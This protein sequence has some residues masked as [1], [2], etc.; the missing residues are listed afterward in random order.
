MSRIEA[1]DLC[2]RLG[3]RQ[4]LAGF[5]AG[6]QTGQVTL[7][8]GRNGA[9]KS[10]LMD[11]LAGLRAPDSGEV[12]LDDAG[13]L[14][15][16]PRVRARSLTFLPQSQDIAWALD[17]RTLVGLGR[18]P[19]RG[20][21]GPSDEDHAA[22]R[23]A[24]RQAGVEALADRDVL[25]LSGGERSRMLIAR[26]LAGAPDWLLADEPL[27]GLDPGHQLDIAGLFRALA[28][29]QGMGVVLTLHDLTLAARIADQVVLMADG[30]CLASGPAREVITPDHLAQAYGVRARV[31]EGEAGLTVEVLD[32]L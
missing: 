22:V 1:R 27:V 4:V 20:A 30:R 7:I 10:T 25:T 2:V 12:R 21:S 6:F 26:A 9:G 13:L 18:L 16:P 23:R 17:G 11:C 29:D 28:R 24:L 31:V 3:P 19:H 15:L 5:S 14:D 8:L 32:R